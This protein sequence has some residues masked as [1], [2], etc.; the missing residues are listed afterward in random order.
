M[1]MPQTLN[2]IARELGHGH[3]LSCVPEGFV[4]IWQLQGEWQRVGTERNLAQYAAGRPEFAGLT[5]WR[6]GTV[7]PEEIHRFTWTDGD[8]YGLRHVTGTGRMRVFACEHYQHPRTLVQVLGIELWSG[9]PAPRMLVRVRGHS[10]VYLRE[11]GTHR[12]DGVG[13]WLAEDATTPEDRG[14]RLDRLDYLWWI[15]QNLGPVY[16]ADTLLRLLRDRAEAL[17]RAREEQEREARE[18]A[19]QVAEAAAREGAIGR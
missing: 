10:E 5:G 18:W 19:R 1:T 14:E 13:L 4:S 9:T 12:V 11:D 7:V 15:D 16:G 6:Q 17:A 8:V 3:A 2:A